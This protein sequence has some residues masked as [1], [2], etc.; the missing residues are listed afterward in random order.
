MKDARGHGSNGNGGGI[1]HQ[2]GVYQIDSMLTPL[3]N[4]TL[5]HPRDNV[6]K[7]GNAAGQYLAQGGD[8]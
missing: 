2:T 4:R 6:Q 3:G 8:D 5:Q 1:A 7:G